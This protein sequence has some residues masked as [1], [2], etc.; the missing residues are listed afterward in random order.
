[1]KKLTAIVLSIIMVLSLVSG[2]AFAADANISVTVRFDASCVADDLSMLYSDLSEAQIIDEEITDLPSEI[3]V[4]VPKGASVKEILLAAQSEAD[5]SAVGVDS[6]YVT[7]VGFVGSEVLENLVSI[8]VGD[9]YSG[10]VFSSAGWT[11]YMDGT[12]LSVGIGDAKVYDSGAVIEGCF[13]L[14]TGWDSNWNAIH[15]DETFIESYKKLKELTEKN[16]DT[17]SFGEEQKSKLQAERAEASALLS[18]IYNDASLNADVSEMLSSAYPDF[19]TSGGMWIG[20]IEKKGVSLWG[21]GSPTERLESAAKEL[22]AA[23]NPQPE[24]LLSELYVTTLFGT[25]EDNL[26]TDFRSDKY[27]YVIC[28]FTKDNFLPKFMKFKSVATSEGA[29]VSTSINGASITASSLS[30]NW[31]QYNSLDW[32][33]N[34]CNTLA[35]TVTPPE[36]SNLSE[37][38]YTVKIFSAEEVVVIPPMSKEERDAK[39]ASLLKNIAGSYTEKSSYWEAMDMGAYKKYAPETESVLSE[40]AKNNLIDLAIFDAIESDKDTELAKAI[41]ALTSLGYD[42]T[43]LY[44]ENSNTPINAIEKLNNATHSTSAWSAP[45]IL[46]AYARDEYSSRDAEIALVTALIASQGENGAWDEFGTID[47]T[48]NVIAGLSLYANDEDAEIRTKVAAAMEKGLSYLSGEQNDD[49][50]YSDLWS[51]KN[52]NSTAMVAIALAAAGVDIENDT[53]F[54]KNGNTIKDGLLSFALEDNSGFGYTDNTEFNDYST[55]QCF[56]ALIA[57]A[58]ERNVY[59]FSDGE[60]VPAR[61][62]SEK[63]SVGGGSSTPSEEKISVKVSI[64]GENSYW[65]NGYTIKLSESEAT[66]SHALIKACS[67]NGIVQTGAEKGYVSSISNGKETLAERDHGPNS[68]WLYKLNG[69]SPLEGIKECEIEN[70]DTILFYYTK[71]YTSESGSGAWSDKEEEDKTEDKKDDESKDTSFSDVPS[72]H[73]AAEYIEKLAKLGIL[74]GRD[75]GFYPEDKITRAEFVTLLSRIDEEAFPQYSATFEDVGEGAWYSES[76]MWAY[77]N[78]IT[79]GVGEKSFAPDKN[80]TREDMA[81]MIVRYAQMKKFELGEEIS[82]KTFADADKISSYASDAV[83]KMQ[84]AGIISGFGDGSFAPKRF[85]TRA[86]TAKM[87]SVL[88]TV[89][90]K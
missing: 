69:I 86:E 44:P 65:L 41:L 28:D 77:E 62:T 19:K 54:I 82:E 35:F 15:Y 21:T 52:S 12:L 37:T 83:S 67:E 74:K 76:V 33:N 8:P 18:E 9:Y 78:G 39:I 63:P 87:I 80:I 1:M 22:S 32:D 10:N 50:T 61:V 24:N 42:A 43:K 20:Y 66:V 89:C 40:N 7:Q 5:F 72:S 29:T 23:M 60:L 2:V 75:G 36:G 58:S 47:T 3:T 68:G 14:Y 51:G 70:G 48:A 90:E 31:S 27:E 17:S 53:R 57:L 49:G 85:A 25:A 64:K 81:V 84:S 11:F 79:N 55:E 38:V 13:G 26:V 45:Y 73:W 30:D 88:L 56:R 6:G 4:T 16:I 71:D 59:D 46:A 34:V